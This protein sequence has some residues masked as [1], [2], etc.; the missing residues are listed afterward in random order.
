MS[1]EIINKELHRIVVTAIVIKDR[2]YLI[3][4]RSPHKKAFPSLW[5]VPGG[6]LETDDYINTK[7][8]NS[9][10][11]YFAL[12]KTLQREVKEE[13]G[14]EIEK[15]QYLLDLASIRPDG[16]PVVTLS[17]YCNWKAGEVKLNEESV[18]YKWVS[19]AEAKNYDFISGILGELDMVDKITKGKNLN[20]IKFNPNL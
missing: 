16:I 9:D 11:W 10:C 17:F 20:N 19:F 13:V 2:K 6:G 14:L 1:Q 18:D 4:K 5:T 8:T 3:T 12:T 7:K 15:I